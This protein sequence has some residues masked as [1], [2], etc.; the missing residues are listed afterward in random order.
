ME[1]S[2]AFAILGQ[3]EMSQ[4]HAKEIFTQNTEILAEYIIQRGK[5][6]LYYEPVLNVII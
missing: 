5:F 4:R 3:V 1:A 2:G 6:Q